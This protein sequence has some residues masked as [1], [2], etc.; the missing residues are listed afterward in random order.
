MRALLAP[1]L[2]AVAT[3]ACGGGA[4]AIAHLEPR[5]GSSIV[6]SA[7]FTL[8][9]DAVTMNL[10]IEGAT[11]GSHGIHI[12][13]KGDCSAAD[14][15]SAGPHWNPSAAMHGS[16][17]AESHHAGDMGN[18]EVG[19]DGRASLSHTDPAWTIGSETSTA[20]EVV[21]R[22]IIIHA[23]VDDFSQPAGNAGARSACGV[24]TLAE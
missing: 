19:T 20:S 15:T 2:L 8:D 21:G 6:G 11:P 16:P 22:A 5:S 7:V 13:E 10:S 24:V 1:A 17:T 18:L 14:G 4:D 3:T 23:V 12:H 9:G